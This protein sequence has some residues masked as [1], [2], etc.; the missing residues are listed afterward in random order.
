MSPEG[1]F[2]FCDKG[3]CD[4]TGG[5]SHGLPF[6]VHVRFGKAESEDD[7]QYRRTG[8]EP[9]IW[10]P[11]VRSG[12]D[13]RSRKDGGQEVSKSVT[14]LQHSG[15]NASRV[16][17]AVFQCRRGRISVQTTH[18]HAEKCSTGEKLAV[19]LAKPSAKFKNDEE[20]IVDHKRPLRV[21]ALARESQTNDREHRSN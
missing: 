9:V 7:E 8:G 20:D 13:K 21:S 6:T 19:V 10:S 5:L 3:T 16:L 2:A 11:A 1:D 12:I 18:G 17:R 14:L 4:V 15:E